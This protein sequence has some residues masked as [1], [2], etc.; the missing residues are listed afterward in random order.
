MQVSLL[1]DCILLNG[2]EDTTLMTLEFSP[3]AIQLDMYAVS[4]GSDSVIS[5]VLRSA[6]RVVSFLTPHRLV[7]IKL[8][9]L[10]PEDGDE[11]IYLREELI[12]SHSLILRGYSITIYQKI[13]IPLALLIL[14]RF[15]T[16]R[17]F[18]DVYT[19]LKRVI[20]QSTITINEAMTLPM[21]YAWYQKSLY[22][23]PPELLTVR[24]SILQKGNSI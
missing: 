23:P 4:L 16:A 2:R 17:R 22:L 21:D 15:G 7:D 19:A 6:A 20:P 9:N 11:D 8:T 10:N 12:K 14:W 3:P 18:L 1:R 24:R 5:C 13:D